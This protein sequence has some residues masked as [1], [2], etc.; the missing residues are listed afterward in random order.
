[1]NTDTRTMDVGRLEQ[2]A[3]RVAPKEQNSCSADFWFGSN[4]DESD[5]VFLPKR[6]HPLLGTQTDV[7]VLKRAC[8]NPTAITRIRALLAASLIDFVS[9]NP[10]VPH[11]SGMDTFEMVSGIRGR[12]RSNIYVSER[13]RVSKEKLFASSLFAPSGA[14]L[15]WLE[16]GFEDPE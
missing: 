10:S 14:Y 4:D 13:H 3:G 8:S 12:R 7:T 16:M 5:A 15:T 1:M 6:P 9:Y 11:T 2:W